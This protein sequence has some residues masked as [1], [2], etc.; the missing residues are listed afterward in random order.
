[1]N[2]FS[3]FS[4]ITITSRKEQEELS[5]KEAVKQGCEVIILS[6]SEVERFREKMIPLYE[7]YCLE[8]MEIVEEIKLMQGGL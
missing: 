7:L 1:M 4:I 6:E 8:Y 3:K 2:R 5:Y